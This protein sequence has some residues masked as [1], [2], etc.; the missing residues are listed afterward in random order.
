MQHAS[1]T[2]CSNYTR[3]SIEWESIS[4]WQLLTRSGLGVLPSVR[5]RDNVAWTRI[6]SQGPGTDQEAWH[7]FV[8]GSDRPAAFHTYRTPATTTKR[9]YRTPKG[10]R[11]T[12]MHHKACRFTAL[13]QTGEG[14]PGQAI[15]PVAPSDWNAARAN[16]SLT[17]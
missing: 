8:T 1:I 13:T 15:S 9:R 10:S 7:S 3:T 16:R 4:S 6:T 17:S 12:G 5:E 2:H 14:R 11:A